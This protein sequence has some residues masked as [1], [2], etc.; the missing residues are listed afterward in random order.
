MKKNTS[1]QH[2]CSI[3]TKTKERKFKLAQIS[4][5]KPVASDTYSIRKLITHSKTMTSL[6]VFLLTL[7]HLALCQHVV[8]TNGNNYNSQ[9]NSASNSIT[10]QL[11]IPVQPFSQV[12]IEC[13]LPQTS[14]NGNRFVHWLYQPTTSGKIMKPSVFCYESK[15]NVDNMKRY[16]VQLENDQ[17][18][19]VYDL[20]I[21]N[22]TY[23]LN[24]GIY[25]CDHTDFDNNQTISREI[26][27]IVLSKYT[28][29]RFS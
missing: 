29:P 18:S 2:L 20:V 14:N 19:G 15:C 7:A 25:Y 6:I 12:R 22:V 1:Q 27:L 10:N 17:D 16:G 26:K 28:V 23:E 9:D 13:K 3:I 8:E 5:I 11:E 4:N 21:N 24:D